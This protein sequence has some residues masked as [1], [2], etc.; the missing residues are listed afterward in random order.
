MLRCLWWTTELKDRGNLLETGITFHFRAQRIP[1][2][3]NKAA[4]RAEMWVPDAA[5]K[6]TGPTTTF[7]KLAASGQP[8][9]RTFC[10]KCGSM[11]HR[12]SLRA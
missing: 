3:D 12:K 1:F 8:T 5:V 7:T 4:R 2:G 6:I 11:I 9:E 10:S